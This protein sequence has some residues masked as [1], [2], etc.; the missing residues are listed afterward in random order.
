MKRIITLSLFILFYWGFTWDSWGQ[1]TNPTA[2]SLPY[3][4]NFGTASFS[5]LPNGWATWA[6]SGASATTRNSAETSSPTA[7]SSAITAATA[8]TTTGGVYGYAA[9]SNGR[10]YIQTSSNTT[11]GAIQAVLAIN[12][13]GNTNI[14]IQYDVE[15]LSIDTRTVGVVMQYRIGTSG[16]WMTIPGVGNPASQVSGSTGILANAKLML[17]TNAE[18]QAVVQL[19]WATL[20][21]TETGNSGGIGIDNVSI[22][23]G[24]SGNSYYSAST[25]SLDLTSSWGTSPDGTGSNPSNFLNP[26]DNFYIRNNISPTISA[27]WTV[28][29][30]VILGDGTNECTF[31]IP[32]AFRANVL[33]A[34]SENSKVVIQNT[35]FPGL[36]NFA[37][38]STV[39]YSSSGTSIIYDQNYP[40]LEISAG[41]KTWSPNGNRTM[42]GN[43][44]IANALFAYGNGVQLTISGNV[45]VD[46]TSTISMSS[47]A[48]RI[49]ASGVG[50]T[51]T[52]NGTARV[53]ANET[54]TGAATSPFSYQYN[55]FASYSF[56]PTSWVSFR[57]PTST[58]VTQGIDGI[59]G[60]PFGNMEIAAITNLGSAGSNTHTFKTNVEIAG[61]LAFPRI[62]ANTSLIINFGSNTVKVGGAIQLNGSNTS[63]QSGGRTYNMG[64]STIELNGTTAQNTLGGTDLPTAFTNLTL[65]NS[66]GVT[67][68]NAVTVSGMLNL[69]G[70][71][72]Y[73]NLNNI[74]GYTGLTYSAT[75]TQT[76]GSELGASITNLTINN[77]NNVTLGGNVTVTG[78]LTLTNGALNK[79]GFTLTLSGS[80]ATTGTG[81][82]SEAQVLN[83]PS[84]ANVGGLGALIT[85]GA[86]LGNTTVTRGY[87][88]LTGNSN[89]GIKR[90]YKITP[91]NNTGLSATL[92]FPYSEGDELN[93]IAEGNLRLFRSTDDGATWTLMTANVTHDQGANTFTITGLDGFSM[94]TLGNSENPLPVELENLTARIIGNIVTLNWST[95]TEVNSHQFVVE[96]S[97]NDVWNAIGSVNAAGNSNSPKVYS[98]TDN[99]L[100]PGKYQYRLKMIDNDGSYEYSSSVEVDIEIPKEFALMQ[101]YPN[102]FNP[103]TNINYT[104]PVNSKVMLVIYSISGEKVAELVNEAQVAGSYSI[105]FNASNLASGTYVYRLI[106][107]DFVQTKK[108]L[109]I[110]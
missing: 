31:T 5:S 27:D 59:S 14:Q 45:Q 62:V 25:G 75:T 6:F 42:S 47:S 105:P 21:G 8:T 43:L 99:N 61:I 23:S 56:A 81:G 36:A 33:L 49:V 38:N 83:N 13:T 109:L 82:I 41:T 48:N 57:S 104:I 77:S 91:A 85:S 97:E 32:S 50:R 79:N 54:Q 69:G 98:F 16:G 7:N 102:P 94:W 29:G 92:V 108:M 55:G 73:T 72:S 46:A 4:Q 30:K 96:K 70:N 107:N 63:T 44:T 53:T 39:V 34:L 10:L 22:T 28:V 37:N 87:S 106:A 12:T 11:N 15:V 2:Q 84:G 60:S 76:T 19:R 78:T 93:L 1:T 68:A 9:A 18:N 89:S 66:T 71:N 26:G 74:T 86:D 88:A 52:L 101:N 95:S 51:F 20:R 80:V 110:K 65:N 64:T 17:P 3:S 103:V 35:S 40:N 90:W 24:H 100:Q 67:I 58:A